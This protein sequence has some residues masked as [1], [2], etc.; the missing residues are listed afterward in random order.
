MKLKNEFEP[1]REWATEKGIYDKS[2]A[3][4]Q[5]EKLDEEVHE[6]FTGILKNDK[7]EIADAIGDCVVCLVNIAHLSGL[8]FED[9]VNYAYKEISER[10][11]KMVNGM[12]VKN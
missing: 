7:D 2:D 12:F 6:L 8:P 5:Y 9:C 1:I 4:K 10:S 11:G 3:K